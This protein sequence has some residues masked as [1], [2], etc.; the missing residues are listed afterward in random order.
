[1]LNQK[2]EDNRKQI[3]FYCMEGPVPKD[4]ILWLEQPAESAPLMPKGLQAACIPGMHIN[5]LFI[6]N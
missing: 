4:H 2:N 1:M 3:G 5:T 6:F